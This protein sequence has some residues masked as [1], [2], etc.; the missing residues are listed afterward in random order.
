MYR[1]Q[2]FVTVSADELV[3]HPEHTYTQALIKAVPVPAPLI[4]KLV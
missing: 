2:I 4:E 3:L 1:G